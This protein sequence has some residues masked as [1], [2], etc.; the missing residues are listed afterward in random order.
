MKNH[1]LPLLA[2]LGFT[3]TCNTLQALTFNVTVPSG[4]NECWIVGNFNGWNNNLNKMT[5]IDST[6]YTLNVPESSFV[7][8]TVTLESLRYKYLSG[9]RDWAFVEKAAD[10]GEI[11]DRSYHESDIVVRW[12][13]VFEEAVKAAKFVTINVL[14][15]KLVTDLYLVGN[16]CNW[17]LPTDSTKMKFLQTTPEGNVFSLKIWT[18]NAYMLQ[19]KFTAGPAWDYVQTEAMNYIFP[20]KYDEVSVVVNSFVSVFNINKLGRIKI[21]A[22][23]PEGTKDCWIQGNFLGWDMNKAQ[24]GIRNEDGRFS[25]VLENVD[26]VEYRLYNS[27]KWDFPEASFD[28]SELQN[29][30]AIFPQDSAIEI[31]VI[32]W[33]NPVA[34]IYDVISPTKPTELQVSTITPTSALIFWNQSFDDVELAGYD[35]FRDG[36]KIGS[37]TATNWLI[38]EL[39]PNTYYWFSVV[40]K[41]AA[42]NKSDRSDSIEVKTKKLKNLLSI[43]S[44]ESGSADLLCDFDASLAFELKPSIG[45][46]IH[47]VFYNGVDV[48]AAVTKKE[49]ILPRITDDTEIKVAFELSDGIASTSV[50]QVQVHSNASSIIVD[51]TSVGESVSIITPSGVILKTVKSEGDRI[52]F[53]VPQG[54]SYLI[55]TATKTVKVAM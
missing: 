3:L 39:T 46:K 34:P 52:L 21:L 18:S 26:K 9:S 7:D 8:K 12:N 49:F 15:P 6:H 33:K 36:V 30:I 29:R 42:G 10:G 41:D 54:A 48:T 4:T 22:Q 28:G 19:Y 24:K 2:F 16:F 27:P 40:A 43:K 55:K 23:V 11:P 45:W 47:S 38:P 53:T 31:S 35:I 17:S 5:K 20:G 1:L 50:S 32:K 13:I 44:A 14:V 37:T 25:F 51:G